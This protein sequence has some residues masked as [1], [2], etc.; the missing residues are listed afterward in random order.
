MTIWVAVAVLAVCFLVLTKCAD[1]FVDGAVGIAEHLKVPQ[2]LIGIVLVSMATTSPELAVSVMSAL[3][4]H[5]EMAL[6]NAV[7]SVIVDDGV[8]LGLGILFASA[9]IAVN[10]YLLRTTGLFLIVVD[11]IAYAM[12]FNDYTLSRYE[13][14]VLVMLFAVYMVFVYVTRKRSQQP[15][16]LAE[17]T[18]IEES[19]E[20]KGLASLL[21]WFM[22]GLL[23]V[24]VS[25]HFIVEAS[26][27]IASSLGVSEAVIGLTIVAIGTSLPEIA[28]AVIAAKKGHGELMVG[29]IL[30]A[31]IL[32]ICWIAGASALVN[33]LVVSRQII[34]FSF[35]AMLIIVIGMLIMMRTGHR[36]TRAEG[37]FLVFLYCVYLAM[38]AK[39]FL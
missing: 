2:M 34:H 25:S 39:L 13:G 22:V 36:L 8:A 5:P 14:A 17:L 11:L 26:V 21:I 19:I 35:P 4:G 32:N 23:G 24:L 20:G 37:V 33:P 7:G 18:E 27:V 1:W 30:G 12:V 10:P 28:T 31:D 38:M 15:Q 3:Q 9:P 6:G 29:N 16:D